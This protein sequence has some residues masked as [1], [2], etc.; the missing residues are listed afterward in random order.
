MRHGEIWLVD[1]AP[2]IGEEID[3]IR[4]ALIVSNDSIGKLRLKVVVPITDPRLIRTILA[5]SNN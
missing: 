4:P 1:F 2:K 5:C 3:K